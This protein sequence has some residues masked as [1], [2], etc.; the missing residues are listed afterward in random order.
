MLLQHLEHIRRQSPQARQRFA[1]T[2][3]LVLTGLIAAIWLSVIFAS[4]VHTNQHNPSETA[5]S[6]ERRPGFFERIKTSATVVTEQMGLHSTDSIEEPQTLPAYDF[7]PRFDNTF[8]E[9]QMQ[10][11]A[12][13]A[14]T[15]TSAG[16][17]TNTVAQPQ[18]TPT[19][20]APQHPRQDSLSAPQNTPSTQPRTEDMSDESFIEDL[21]NEMNT[22]G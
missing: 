5:E 1:V 3:S 19:T 20:T 15:S 10:H 18:P 6:V 13:A 22:S 4:G 12:N 8:K 2:S 9:T 16:T 17:T 11:T 7:K 21:L 14:S